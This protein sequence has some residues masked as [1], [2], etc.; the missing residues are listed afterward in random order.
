MRISDG[1]GKVEWD[2][3]DIVGRNDDLNNN[4]QPEIYKEELENR[5]QSFVS[6]IPAPSSTPSE[7]EIATS[8][9]SVTSTVSQKAFLGG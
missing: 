6:T 4:D 2:V 5:E 1:I 8:K 7:I 3:Y 9:D